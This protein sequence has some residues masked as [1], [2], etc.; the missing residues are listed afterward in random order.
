M[1]CRYV[2]GTPFMAYTEMQ[3]LECFQIWVVLSVFMLVFPLICAKNII[4]LLEV[5]FP[6]GELYFHDV[7]NVVGCIMSTEQTI[8]QTLRNSFDT[9]LREGSKDDQRAG[10]Q[11]EEKTASTAMVKVSMSRQGPAEIDS[12]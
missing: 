5:P 10:G 2:L 6:S 1:F 3:H 9:E 4:E 8:F 11:D 12:L 7:F